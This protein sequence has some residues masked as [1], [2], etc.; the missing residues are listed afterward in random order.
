MKV[1]QEI[2]SS[3]H[4][5]SYILR[6]ESTWKKG[7]LL[8]QPTKRWKERVL[9]LS[10]TVHKWTPSSFRLVT[11]KLGL[12]SVPSARIP[13]GLILRQP[14][15]LQVEPSNICRTR[16]TRAFDHFVFYRH[17]VGASP[18]RLAPIEYGF[19]PIESV[20]SEYQT[21][22]PKIV[23]FLASISGL[24]ASLDVEQVKVPGTVTSSAAGN[25]PGGHFLNFSLVPQTRNSMFTLPM[26]RLVLLG[27]QDEPS[28]RELSLSFL[29]TL[30]SSS[31][32]QLPGTLAYQE[33]F[34]S[35]LLTAC[36]LTLKVKLRQMLLSLEQNP[37]QL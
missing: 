13:S 3:F 21:L 37:Y 5:T 18:H 1:L 6:G 23:P 17:L 22:F 9:T 8:R 19:G 35:S 33:A 7:S 27:E 15:R 10:H 30:P 16:C 11:L 34:R 36:S 14:L 20:D 4:W 32:F 28:Y 29:L 12:V 31:I 2:A 25:T 26:G 24:T